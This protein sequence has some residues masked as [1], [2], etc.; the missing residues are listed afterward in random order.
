MQ[1]VI[2]KK[3]PKGSQKK[4]LVVA[5]TK[6][7]FVLA[8]KR[9]KAKRR[10]RAIFTEILKNTSEDFFVI[11]NHNVLEVSFEDLRKEIHNKVR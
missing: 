2:V 3:K 8:V 10:I 6:K 7:E 9:N 4:R 11:P 5:V 1:T